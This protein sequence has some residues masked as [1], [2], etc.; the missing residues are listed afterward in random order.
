MRPATKDQPLT[1]G[2]FGFETPTPGLPAFAI[3]EN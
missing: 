1:G 3:A 2:L